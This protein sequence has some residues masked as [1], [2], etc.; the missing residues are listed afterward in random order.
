MI[1]LNYELTVDDLIVEYMAYKVKNGYEPEF[2][3]SEFK[4]FLDFFQSKMEVKDVI[5]DNE[6]LFKRFFV[7]K[8]KNDWHMGDFFETVGRELHME[9]IYSEEEKNYVIKAGYSFSDYDM[10]VI[11]TYFMDK[12][13]TAKTRS[14]IDEFLSSQSKRTID[15][16]M[17]IEEKDLMIGKCFSAQII[18]QIWLSHI[19][20]QVEYQMWPK[21]C[22]DINKYLF[23]IDLAQIIG[24]KSIKNELIELYDVMSKRIAILYKQDK[25]LKVT[26]YHGS[27]LANANYELLIQGYEDIIKT[28][29][30]PYKKS[31]DI[32]LSTLTFT[33]IH[34][35]DGVYFE[36]DDP[37]LKANTLSIENDDTKKL[38]KNIEKILT[39]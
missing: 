24:V 8:N 5:D 39:K 37:E 12:G 21:Q 10:S 33:E 27:Y 2:T 38:V 18:T 34:E 32:D 30:G 3:V 35:V 6:R 17:K 9:M 29:F 16:S 1:N 22:T 26:S 28:T 13:K 25:G 20:E 36:D 15:E 19:S 7:R 23:D 31:F 4:S 14:I 11:N